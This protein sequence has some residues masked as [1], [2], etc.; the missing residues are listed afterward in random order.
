MTVTVGGADLSVTPDTGSGQPGDVLGFAIAGGVAPYTV[1]SSAPTVASA[2]IVGDTVRVLLK[3]EGDASLAIKDATGQ[4]FVVSVSSKVVLRELKIS[5]ADAFGLVNDTV[6]ITVLD[7]MGPF[8]AISSNALVATV[9]VDG[10]TIRVKLLR[11]GDATVTVL[12]SKNQMK[13]VAVKATV[14][15]PPPAP[16]A[17]VVP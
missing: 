11:E 2:E 9:T 17:P 6:I 8:K 14:P 3:A 13:A 5:P 12:D 10:L 1:S 4:S 16:P 15:T 7:G